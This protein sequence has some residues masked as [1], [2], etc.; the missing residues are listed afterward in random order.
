M[1]KLFMPHRPEVSR[2]DAEG[3]S[4]GEL[5]APQRSSFRAEAG[6]D[7]CGPPVSL[8]LVDSSRYS[9]SEQ[10]RLSALSSYSILDTLPER[11]FDDVAELASLLCGTT[12]AQVSF[13]DADRQWI[14]ASTGIK[15]KQS[16]RSSSFCAHTLFTAKPLIVGDAS[17]DDQ[18]KSNP[19]VLGEPFIRSYAGAP[20][21]DRDGQVL[22]T[23]CVIDTSP[24]AFSEA[25]IAGLR[26]LA[27]QVVTL[28]EHRQMLVAQERASRD[29]RTRSQ[30]ALK[31]TAERLHLSQ[32]AGKIASWEWDIA[33]GSFLWNGESAWAYGRPASELSTI[34]EI[35]RF[36]HPE[37]VS[38]VM[39]AIRPALE[40]TG[41]YRAE[42][43][44][45]WPDGTT[46]WSQAFGKPVL[47]ARGKAARIVG[48]NMDITAR[49]DAEEALLQHEKLAVVGRLAS[50][51]AHEINNPLESVTNLIYLARTSEDVQTAREYLTTAD[52]ELRRVSEIANQTLRFHKQA[53]KPQEVLCRDLLHGVLAV[54]QSRIRNAQVDVDT[55]DRAHRPVLCFEGE[56]RQV[57]NNLVANAVD[58][59]HATGGRLL[60][61]SREGCDWK[62][63]QKG[64]VL[65][66][67][68]TGPGICS[69]NASRIFEA[70]FTTKSMNGTGLGLWVS[71]EIMNRHHGQLR[72]RSSQ[73]PEHHGTVFT[74][75]LPFVAT[76]R[77]G[78]STAPMACCSPSA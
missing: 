74:V 11:G 43:R 54:Q 48:I 8:R 29:T 32:E 67:A 23:V 37:D 17:A 58:A 1:Q 30:A 53:T 49:K 35:M 60:L 39:E 75:F 50:S 7:L 45:Q 52:L 3:S 42:F 76:R 14:K 31:E 21:V 15:A 59:M 38:Q 6:F 34:Q 51:I 57:L 70:F 20:I 27:R 28:L 5:G 69:E 64:V 63:G 71:Q 18:F 12:I 77:Q 25:E 24:R 72:V 66:V 46:H 56:I 78:L 61:R 16:P 13:I 19:L 65:T 40:G 62:D 36:L 10:E 26:A 41:D 4:H 33:T 47:D 68:D 73:H 2:L 22:G 44:V 55:A 9:G